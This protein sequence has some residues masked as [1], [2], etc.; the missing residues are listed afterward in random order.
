MGNMLYGI[1]DKPSTSQTLLFGLQIVLSCF[2]AT[3]LIS[4]ICGV[5]ASG[6]LI[7][8]G[9]STI[10]YLIITRFQSPMFISSSGAFVAPVMLALA[11]GGYTAVA[12]GGLVTAI[13]YCVFGFI[14]MKIPVSSIYKVFPKPLIGA[15]TIVIGV[16]L[17]GF[18]G[19]YCQVNGVTSQWG[20][21]VAL[22][23]MLVVA[24]IS[25][26][27]KGIGKILPFLLGTIAGYVFAIILTVT[28][29][30]PLVDF[31]VFSSASL[32]SLPDFAFTH[33]EPV[34]FAT[35][36]PIIVIYIAYTCSAM[37]EALSDHKVLSNIIGVDL[38]EK[39]GLGRIFIGEGLG[40]IVGTC[41]GGL[42]ICSYGESVSVVGFSRV[43][44][45]RVTL[46]SAIIM[47][48]LGFFTPVQMFIESI[49]SCVFGGC[50]MI[51]YSFI[52]MSGVKTLQSVDLNNN[53][54]LLIAGVPISLGLCGLAIG[55]VTFSL[56][57]TALGL[58]IGVILNLVLRE[59][60]ETN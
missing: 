24:F 27:S 4:T 9:L 31:S 6:A 59:K 8:A 16:A 22:F 23:T 34:K 56:S 15:V 60:A 50:S 17:M 14:F 30:A 19:T 39:P 36:I 12:V 48:V 37:M 2:V 51:L 45:T 38:Y 25:H 46:V 41:V 47:V 33:W 58:I 42:G 18:I 10:L 40:N 13:V 7:G 20:I 53:R 32:F 43:A 57:G 3:V 52:A 35:L 29:V 1:H 55:G 21:I 44:C 26:Y 49:P 5:S 11:A 54:N 28:G